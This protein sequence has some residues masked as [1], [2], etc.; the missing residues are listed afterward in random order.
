MRKTAKK[1][2]TKQLQSIIHDLE[3]MK[4]KCYESYGHKMRAPEHIAYDYYKSLDPKYE[5]EWLDNGYNDS[6]GPL[7]EW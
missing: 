3:V 2:I 7:E 5:D 4:N 1:E 6:E